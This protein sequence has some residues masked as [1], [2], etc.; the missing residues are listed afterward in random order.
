LENLGYR[1]FPTLLQL[2]LHV[3]RDGDPAI[4]QIAT[5]LEVFGLSFV[6]RPG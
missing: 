1:I 4:P 5:A 3:S 2:W 6:F